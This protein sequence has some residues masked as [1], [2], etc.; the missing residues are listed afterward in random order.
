ME[1][2]MKEILRGQDIKPAKGKLGVLI[3]GIG[4]VTTTL[5]AG[6]F[7]ARKGIAKPLGSVTQMGKIRL[8]KRTDNRMIPVK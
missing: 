8:G 7:A 6:V 2:N 4:A 3:P 5:L 1:E